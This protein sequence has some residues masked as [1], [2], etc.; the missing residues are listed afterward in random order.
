MLQETR[1]TVPDLVVVLPALTSEASYTWLRGKNNTV[2]GFASQSVR[3]PLQPAQ[4][5][6][7][8]RRQNVR[9]SLIRRRS[10][11]EKVLFETRCP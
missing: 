11:F 9:D 4:R 2:G 10:Q 7:D 3:E 8:G 5:W 6:P 1:R